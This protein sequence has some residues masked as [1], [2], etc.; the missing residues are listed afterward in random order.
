MCFACGRPAKPSLLV[1]ELA[2]DC[3][4]ALWALGDSALFLE[5]EGLF[6]DA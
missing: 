1:E 6:L 5:G 4:G 2:D 3:E